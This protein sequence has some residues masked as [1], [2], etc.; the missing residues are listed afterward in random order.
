MLT[1]K[2]SNDIL[3]YLFLFYAFAIPLSRAGVVVSTF[4]IVIFWFIE[5]DLKNKFHKIIQQKFL[6]ALFAYILLLFSS[7]FWVEEENLKNGLE[8]LRKFL[9]ILPL[10]ALYTSI[11]KEYIHYTL[12]AFLLAMSI[13]VVTSMGMVAGLYTGKTAVSFFI[14]NHIIYSFF[15]SFTTLMLISLTIY[16]K[17]KKLQL[18]YATLIPLFLTVLF[19]SEARTGQLIF[20]IGLFVLLF[21]IIKQKLKAF[22]LFG[23]GSTL[24]FLLAYNYNERFEHR[25]DLI[26]SDLSHI[27]KGNICNSL[28]GRVFTWKVASTIAKDDPLL[29]LGVADHTKYL[30]NAMEEDKTFAQCHVLKD[31]IDYFHSQY[32]EVSSAIGIIGLMIFLSIFYF[33]AQLKVQDKKITYLKMILLVVFL[34]IFIVDVPF[35]KQLGLALFALIGGIILARTRIENKHI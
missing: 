20:F 5:G 13:S 21:M 10:V 24:I 14:S 33:L 1:Q 9:Y 2:R 6:I 34:S 4:L 25:M 12:S 31:M 18:F 32:I 19:F 22:L 3:N 11:K 29:G 30:K 23:L 16:E 7:L 26:G 8:Y 28:G 17:N 35:R 27:S 15:L